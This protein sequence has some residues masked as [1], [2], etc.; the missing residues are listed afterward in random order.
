MTLY[1]FKLLSETE[2]ASLVWDEG[3]FIANRENQQHNYLLYQLHS[4]YVEVQYERDKNII[5][6]FKSF[7]STEPLAPYLE[8]IILDDLINYL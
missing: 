7:S 3:V 6:A 8:T 4:F 2:Q 5:S 1:Q